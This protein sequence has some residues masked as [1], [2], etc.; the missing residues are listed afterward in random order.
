LSNPVQI[1]IEGFGTV[2]IH[3]TFV[4]LSREEQDRVIMSIVTDLRGGRGEPT[5]PWRPL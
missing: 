2:E 3:R 5:L 1:N 4:S